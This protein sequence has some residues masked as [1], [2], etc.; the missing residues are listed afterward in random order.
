MP[1]GPR[2]AGKGRM[3]RS[4]TKWGKRVLLT[5]LAPGSLVGGYTV[6]LP[7][8]VCARQPLGRPRSLEHLRRRFRAGEPVSLDEAFDAAGLVP[9][10]RYVLVERL[11]GR[12][13]GDI[14][15]DVAMRKPRGSPYTRQ[16][17]QQL[18]ADALGKLGVRPSL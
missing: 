6:H 3:F 12:S 13:Y 14:A 8:S 2:G 4:P 7:S 9:R 10:E 11:A 1:R 17:I 15:A 16:R 18:E 5:R